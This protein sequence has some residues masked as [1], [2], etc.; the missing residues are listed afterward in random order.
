[1][2]KLVPLTQTRLHQLCKLV[3]LTD[4]R[5]HPLYKLVPLTDTR[6][7]K[8]YKL[9]PLTDTRWH[10]LYKLVPLTDTRWHQLYITGKLTLIPTLHWRLHSNSSRA[11]LTSHWGTVT[12]IMSSTGSCTMGVA[13][14]GGRIHSFLTHALHN[15]YSGRCMIHRVKFW[16]SQLRPGTRV[17]FPEQSF[18]ICTTADFR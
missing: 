18:T 7:H 4:T 3:P 5:W 8:L 17:G 1:L 13:V 10:L 11:G 2:Y 6:W 15:R 14:S 9:V 16:Q 12:M